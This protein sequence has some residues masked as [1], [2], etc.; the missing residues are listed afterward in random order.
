MLRAVCA[1]RMIL[2]S[3]RVIYLELSPFAVNPIFWFS[4]W[5]NKITG[6]F[7]SS[8]GCGPDCRPRPN[9]SGYFLIRNFFFPDSKISPSTRSVFKSNSPVHTHPMVS[10]FTLVPKAPLHLNVFRACAV[11]LDSVG[12]FA[13][14][15][16]HVVPQCRFIV[17]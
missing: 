17:Q 10:G 5:T 11:E 4:V 13:L 8:S 14:F 9:V 1:S 16:R 3:G 6:K 7:I 12:K 15:A 2:E